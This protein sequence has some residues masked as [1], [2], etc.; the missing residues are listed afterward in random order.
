MTRPYTAKNSPHR[1]TAI[2]EMIQRQNGE[3]YLS[4]IPF[5]PTTPTISTVTLSNDNWTALITDMTGV[6]EWKISELT[7]ANFY[8][9]YV[10]APGNNFS[11]GYAWVGYKTKP[12]AIYVKRVSAAITLKLEIWKA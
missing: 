12:S 1:D 3:P 2:V 4:T 11:V 6:L 7:G 10:A 9:A 5:I 8:Y